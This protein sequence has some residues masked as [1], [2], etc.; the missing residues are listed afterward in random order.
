MVHQYFSYKMADY[1]PIDYSFRC[2]TSHFLWGIFKQFFITLSST[3]TRYFSHCKINYSIYDEPW[4]ADRKVTRRTVRR[5]KTMTRGRGERSKRDLRV[6]RKFSRWVNL[7][8]ALETMRPRLLCL[9]VNAE[10]T[11]GYPYLIKLLLRI[12]CQTWGPGPLQRRLS[13]FYALPLRPYR[14]AA[15]AILRTSTAPIAAPVFFGSS[16]FITGN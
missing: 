15:K 11:K 8:G 14:E 7:S 10:S 4:S 5:R 12:D 9:R 6:Y 1:W 13:K 16:R 2:R 3:L